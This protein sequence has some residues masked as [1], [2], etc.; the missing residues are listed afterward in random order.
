[1]SDQGERRDHTIREATGF[2]RRDQPDE[3]PEP[4]PD[5]SCADRERE[6][7][8]QAL[9]D[10]IDD[11]RLV[12][13][14]LQLRREQLLQQV[15]PLD[16][17]RLVEPEAVADRPDVPRSRDLAGDPLCGVAARD[18]DEDQVDDEADREQH[19]HHPEDPP[20]DVGAHL[21]PPPH[22]CSILILAR[23]S[24][25]SRRPSPKTLIA[26]TV[27]MIAMPAK[28][29]ICGAVASEDCPSSIIVPQDGF[30]TFTPAP[31]KERPTSVRIAFAMMSVK[32]TSTEEAM[33]GS[34]SVNMIRVEPAPCAVAASMNSRLRRAST[35]P[36]S[37]LPMY[38]M[39]TNAITNTVIQRLEPE[40]LR[41][42]K[43]PKRWKP[44]WRPFTSRAVPSAIASRMTGNAQMRSKKREMIQSTI[45]PK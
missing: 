26:S 19:E 41:P 35:W 13:V 5:D 29:L 2:D 17:E 33:F 36:R 38:G 37:G 42:M 28:R 30:G 25:A 24:R 31:R 43:V 12:G 6:R 14:G 44:W 15:P 7:H 22:Q 18:D 9:L 10:L 8:R 39:K 23:G 40:R 20:D 21:D 32:S 27:I 1:D 3:D 4:H 45:P 34:S 11:V 16:D